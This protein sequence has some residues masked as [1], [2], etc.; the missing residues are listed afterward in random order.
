M[1]PLALFPN[2]IARYLFGGLLIGAATSAIYVG[3]GHRAGASSVL[4]ALVSYVSG[5][6]RFQRFAASRDWRV[7][8]LVGIVLGAGF[9]ALLFQQGAWLTEVQ[10]WRLF[11]GGLLVGV[12]TRLGRG[13]TS[14][15]GICG[16]SS[17]SWASLVNV[18]LFVLVAV[19][20]AQVLLA[21]GVAP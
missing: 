21:V 11:L 12:G 5:A 1:D 7:L 3:T 17:A 16:L 18:A 10:P 19:G 2:G 4:D 8:L 13:C 15:H 6:E 9:W 20:T 14:G